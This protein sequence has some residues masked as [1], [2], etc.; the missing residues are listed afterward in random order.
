MAKI[1]FIYPNK[2]GRGITPIWIASHYSI[3]KQDHKVE[4]FDATFYKDW[5]EN[6]LEFN[7]KNKQYKESNYF[8]LVKFSELPIKNELQNKIDSFKPDIIF[9][10]ALSS[11]IHGEGEYV[12]IEYGYELLTKVNTHGAKL[13]TGGLQATASPSIVFDN[14]KN[15]DFLIQGESE[16][17]LKEFAD[18]TDKNIKINSINGLVYLDKY[19]KIISNQKQKILNDLDVLPDYDYTLFDSQCFLRP[20][21]GKVL[22]VI[23][24]ELSRGCIYTCS[25]CVETVIQKY[26][27]F[28][29]KTPKGALK[30]AKNY[31]RN[32]SPKKVYRELADVRDKFGIELVRSQDTN[33]LT[34]EPQLL[35][36]LE[37]LI[38]DK[39]LNMKFYIETRPEGIN[40]KSVELLKNLGVDGV[41]MGLELAGSDF[42]EENLNRYV[43][44][45]RIVKAFELLKKA[46][47]KRTSYNI[48][49]LPKQTEKDILETIKFNKQL[50]PDNITV[51][52][53]TPYLGTTEQMKSTKLNYFGSY[54]KRIDSQL[55]SVSKD[56][57]IPLSQ[58]NYYKE[59]FYNLVKGNQI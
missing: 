29:E 28:E 9:W 18:K 27:G 56:E 20:Y 22:K 55:R 7:T 26:Y 21:N 44:E 47:I 43:N 36:G 48:I 38:L 23:D 37:K 4:L 41:G 31:L 32:K 30:K 11:H 8:D 3:L 1:L 52:F 46:G 50:D 19:K 33:F 59:N 51:A 13:I 25:Y 45:D 54:E 17:V 16:L 5:T 57:T 24:Y 34:I 35:K 14:F 10:S 12:N 2:W 40:E 49:G 39:P 58:L 42:R 6:E 15:I 53:Y